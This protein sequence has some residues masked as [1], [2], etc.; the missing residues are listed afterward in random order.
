M[1]HVLFLVAHRTASLCL[2]HAR[3]AVL[4]WLSNTSAQLP[5]LMGAVAPGHQHC[6]LRRSSDKFYK[7]YGMFVTAVVWGK[8]AAPA[9]HQF[10]IALSI[11]SN[12]GKLAQE[13]PG[14][15]GYSAH[16]IGIVTQGEGLSVK[17]G[18]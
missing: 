2:W 5:Q 8:S 13:A 1:V 10:R 7:P 18:L 9:Q 11:R 17:I 4:H 12:I 6:C 3:G 14:L 16:S 15:F